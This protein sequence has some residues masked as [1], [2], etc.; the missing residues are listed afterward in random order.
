MKGFY[1]PISA[2]NKTYRPLSRNINRALRM[3]EENLKFSG[4]DTLE[5]VLAMFVD[6]QIHLYQLISWVREESYI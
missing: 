4:K 3:R 6:T 1:D 2:I 5:S